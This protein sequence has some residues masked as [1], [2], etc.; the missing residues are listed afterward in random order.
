MGW[1]EGI[2]TWP[3]LHLSLNLHAASPSLPGS[4]DSQCGLTGLHQNTPS[5]TL[6]LKVTTDSVVIAGGIWG[7]NGNGNNIIK[8]K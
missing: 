8:I 2:N 1:A 7:L 4:Q 6:A 3:E 5:V